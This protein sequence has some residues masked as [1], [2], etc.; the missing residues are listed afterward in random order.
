MKKDTFV[1]EH[2]TIKH[3][4]SRLIRHQEITLQVIAGERTIKEVRTITGIPGD[5]ANND[6][7]SV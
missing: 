3:S 2:R 1:T 5:G 7:I 6:M 4:M